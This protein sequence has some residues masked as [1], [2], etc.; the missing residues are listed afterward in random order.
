[1]LVAIIIP[2]VATAPMKFAIA[3]AAMV[4]S[5]RVPISLI[6]VQNAYVD[7]ARNLGVRKALT[8]NADY[9]LFCDSDMSFPPDALHR[10]LAADKD[11][12]GANYIRR[13]QPHTSLAKPMGNESAEVAGIVEVEQLP[14]GFVLIKRVVFESMPEPWFWLSMNGRSTT[15]SLD[16]YMNGILG[17]DYHFCDK[18]REHGIRIW[19]D[20]ELSLEVVH[21]GQMG[22]RWA[23][24]ADRYERVEA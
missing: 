7:L 24:N 1:M 10:L 8:Q 13:A 4:G 14:T 18:A 23:D 2:S 5:S 21:W 16:H 9:V 17:E 12:I 3:L 19:M 20:T 11:I 22:F 15:E 6:N